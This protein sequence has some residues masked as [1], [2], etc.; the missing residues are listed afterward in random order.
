MRQ[1]LSTLLALC[2]LLTLTPAALGAQTP[3]GQDG[4]WTWTW[5][6]STGLHTLTLGGTTIQDADFMA[7]VDKAAADEAAQSRPL[8]VKL[9]GDAAIT[10]PPREDGGQS[11]IKVFEGDGLIQS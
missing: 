10:D 9:S 7:A 2:L 6:E 8:I 4:I 3:M 5:E 11:T 1:M